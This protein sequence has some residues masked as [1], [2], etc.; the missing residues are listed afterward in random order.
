MQKGKKACLA[1]VGL[2][3][4]AGC[5]EEEVIMHCYP[6][7]VIDQGCG[8]VLGILDPEAAQLVDS[9]PR[10]DTVYV[11]TFDLFPVYQVRGK[12][13]FITLKPIAPEDAPKCPGFIP[14]IYPHVKLL[15]VSEVPCS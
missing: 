13:L 8:T 15:N 4:L 12:K 2:A 7:V 1:L 11:N 3:I 10:N 6:A 5:K 9:K 14:D